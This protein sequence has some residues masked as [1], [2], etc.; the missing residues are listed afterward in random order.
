MKVSMPRMESL[1]ESSQPLGDL[2]KKD[3]E[4]LI[5]DLV[6]HQPELAV[7]ALP[8]IDPRDRFTWSN[9]FVVVSIPFVGGLVGL[10]LIYLANPLAISWLSSSDVPAFYSNSLWNIPKSIPQIQAE[11]GRSYLKL[12]ESYNLKT[13]ETIYTVLETETQNIREIRLYQTIWDRGVEKYLLVSTTT[14]AGIDEYFVRSPKLKYATEAIPARLRP[15]RNRLPLK[16]L[17]LLNNPPSQFNGIWF[18]TTGNI[19]GI[20]Y[21][22]IYYFSNDK[23]SQLVELDVWTS[24]VGE[25][26]IW[27]NALPS[28]SNSVQLVVN[29]TQTYEPSLLIFQPEEV[30]VRSIRKVQ[31]R[32]VTLNEAKGQPKAYQDAL[33]MASVG[34]WS[35]ALGKFNLMVDD[36]RSQG[37]QLSPFLQEQYDLIALHAK[38]TSDQAQNPNSNL[39]EKALV[40]IIDG[41]WSEALEIVN[42][43]AYKGDKI[44]EMLAKYHP[45]I[46]QRVMTMLTFT[47]AKEIKLWGGLIVL[48][49]NGLRR[50]EHWLREQKVDPKESNQLLQRLDLAPVTLDP[51][52][53]I[54][55]VAYIGK[56]DAGS[57][58]FLP[59]P[60]LES[61]QGWYEV[62]IN[63][64]KDGDKWSNAPFSELSDRSSILLWR[65]LGLSINSSLGVVLYDPN[66]KSQTA[67]L[68]AHSLWVSDNGSLRILASGEVALAPLLNKSILQPLVTS[69]GGFNPPNGSP[70][71]WQS[72]SSKT[73]E[74]IVRTM[75]RELQ[76]NGEVS[77]SIEDFGVLV[78]QQWTLTSVSLDGSGKPEYLLLLDREKV[79]LG[80]RHYPLAIAFSSDGSLIFSDMSGG[81]IWIDVLPSSIDGQILTLRNGR[82]EVWNF[83]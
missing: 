61:G 24:P 70:V 36:L 62:N 74:R 51:R 75:Y 44:A 31:L 33:V 21:G 57:E 30:I 11:L 45:H 27:R 6:N 55:T 69:G 17:S 64:M 8:E 66:G 82:Y 13:G 25:L 81:R 65:I 40:N 1:P 38:I 39:G 37:K 63:L 20:A 9:F 28:N 34:L 58:W 41:R 29:Q 26:P 7:S 53:L 3:R 73:I 14:V 32:Q 49:R 19:G 23:R 4:S 35:P 68:T 60:K 42:D 15:D 48:Q 79:D 80:D 54:G 52:Q 78:Q 59:P 12:G 10:G 67:T 2:V 76:R 71:K 50:A 56:G 47:G 43:T 16:K 18:S 22:Q 83:R 46:W 5:G 77:L 72:L